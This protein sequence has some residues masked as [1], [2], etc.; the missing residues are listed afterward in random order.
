MLEKSLVALLFFAALAVG[1]W[2]RTKT[3]GVKAALC[4]S[5]FVLISVYLAIAFVSGRALYN[6][7]DLMQAIYGPMAERVIGWLKG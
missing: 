5:L 7:T 4:Y 3:M 1:D 6:L 2:K